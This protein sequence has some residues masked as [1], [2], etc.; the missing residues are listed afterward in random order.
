M[1][2]AGPRSSLNKELEGLHLKVYPNNLYCKKST[3]EAKKD[4][5][6]VKMNK[7]KLQA[8]AIIREY[9]NRSLEIQW[10]ELE[11]VKVTKKAFIEKAGSCKGV[12]KSNSHNIVR[13]KKDAPGD[14]AYFTF[15]GGEKCK[16]TPT[17]LHIKSD[18]CIVSYEKQ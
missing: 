16:E 11:G 18:F 5:T 4:G 10:D 7:L 3:E 1:G 2:W 12:I 13:E 15:H 14:K 17:H 9:K 8:E 6:L